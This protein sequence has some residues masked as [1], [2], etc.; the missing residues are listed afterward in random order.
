MISLDQ[1]TKEATI[2]FVLTFVTFCL[3]MLLT[4]IYTHFAYKYKLWKR[5]RTH[6]TTGEALQVV[7]AQSTRKRNVPTMAGLIVVI[8]VTVVSHLGFRRETGKLRDF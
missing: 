7:A 6:S 1:I 2:I 4:P 5:K 3:A 8:A